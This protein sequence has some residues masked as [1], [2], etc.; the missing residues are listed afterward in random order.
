MAEA[1][2][3]GDAPPPFW[4]ADARLKTRSNSPT[5]HP[6]KSLIWT[7]VRR[8][9]IDHPLMLQG[10]THI[11]TEEGCSTPLKLVKPKDK[12]Y[13]TNTLAIAHAKKFHP[14]SSG[15]SFLKDEASN[16]VNVSPPF[17]STNKNNCI[18]RRSLLSLN[19][20]KHFLK[21]RRCRWRPRHR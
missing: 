17:C 5:K 21:A 11:C 13:W 20:Q 2:G 15:K 7:S 3:A 1:A 14:D 9:D 8:L 12:D 6:S 10:F 16:K 18:F 4:K 19:T